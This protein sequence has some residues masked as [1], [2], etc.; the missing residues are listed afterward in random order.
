L[1]KF[2]EIQFVLKKKALFSQ[3]PVCSPQAVFATLEQ[4]C[5]V[6]VDNTPIKKSHILLMSASSLQILKERLK[7][8]SVAVRQET[9]R[10][11]V[12]LA[13]K[14]KDPVSSLLSYCNHRYPEVVRV[15]VDGT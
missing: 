5:V 4:I 8:D 12:D 1:K 3:L 7:T 15:A 11:L 10:K 6:W 2:I 9:I 14:E 13:L